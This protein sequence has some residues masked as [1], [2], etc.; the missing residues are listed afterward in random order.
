MVTEPSQVFNLN[1]A[2]YDSS[3]LSTEGQQILKLLTEA[4]NELL[5]LE[6]HKALIEAG[7]QQLI[8]QL[9]PLL[10]DPVNSKPAGTS[11]ILGCASDQIPTTP[12]EKPEEE[13]AP[14][15]IN[16]PEEIRAKQP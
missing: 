6:N 13:P 16:I 11:G 1:G 4:Q 9:K 8:Q 10:T 3:K 12:V 2:N 15:P 14:F 5:R 7:Q